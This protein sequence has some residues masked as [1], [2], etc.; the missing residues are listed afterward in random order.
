MEALIIIGYMIY[1]IKKCIS[2]ARNHISLYRKRKW[3]QSH[4]AREMKKSDHSSLVLHFNWKGDWLCNLNAGS[5]SATYGLA[6]EV[7]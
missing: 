1:Q 5:F 6:S 2:A 4:F 3:F 7:W